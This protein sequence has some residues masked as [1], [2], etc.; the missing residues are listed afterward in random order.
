MESNTA[1]ASAET[2]GKR[3]QFLSHSRAQTWPSLSWDV[4]DTVV[5][6]WH[7][8]FIVQQ[9]L[10]NGSCLTTLQLLLD[11]CLLNP[12]MDRQSRQSVIELC[13]WLRSNGVRFDLGFAPLLREAG[14]NISARRI[15]AHRL[16]L[17]I[18]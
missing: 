1:I 8:P 17:E 12:G 6:R 16:F 5:D 14:Q 3:Q 2:L 4:R 9:T 7:H 18:E 11:P 15:K 13:Q 10:A